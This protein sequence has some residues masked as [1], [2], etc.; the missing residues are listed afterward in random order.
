MT[1]T[2]P[3]ARLNLQPW[4]YLHDLAQAMQAVG[5]EPFVV[6]STRELARWDGIPVEHHPIPGDFRTGDGIRRILQS[7]QADSGLCRMTATIFFRR[8][9]GQRRAFDG[10]LAGVFLRPLHDG[11]DLARRFLDPTLASEIRLDVHHAGL[12]VSRR[13]GTWPESTSNFDEFVFLWESDRLCAVSAG[14]PERICSLVRHPFDPFFRQADSSGLGP[15]LADRIEPSTRRVIFAGPP[16]A[17][18]GVQDAL[19]LPSALRSNEPTQLLVFLREP[20]IP[21]PI[22]SKMRSG[23]HTTYVVRGLI[24]RQELRSAYQASQVA[25]FPYRF[26][27]TALPLVILEAVASGIP[28][29]TTRVHPIRELEGRTGL[30]FASPRDP[31]GLASAV[32]SVFDEGQQEAIQRRNREWIQTT[33]DWPLVAARLV[34]ILRRNPS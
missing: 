10:R 22:V 19:R 29:V 7:R 6:T 18:R 34:S 33:P 12:Y 20:R 8:A 24:S 17:T 4:R 25:V 21:E 1:E 15:R 23:R 27:R 26:V 31:P 5:H 14:L 9:R 30:V 3:T 16:E 11:S 28:V 2:L 32:E 13:L